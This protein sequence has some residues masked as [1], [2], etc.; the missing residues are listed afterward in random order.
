VGNLPAFALEAIVSYDLS[1]Q[2]EDTREIV[3]ST[4]KI[5]KQ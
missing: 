1:M 4:S 5:I 2:R 3:Y